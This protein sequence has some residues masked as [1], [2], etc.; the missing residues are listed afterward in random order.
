[1]KNNGKFV[2]RR[3]S[4]GRRRCWNLIRSERVWLW[5]SYTFANRTQCSMRTYSSSSRT[6]SVRL[7]RSN[8][9][10]CPFIQLSRPKLIYLQI[11]PLLFRAKPKCTR[12]D[13]SKTI[14]NWPLVC[15]SHTN[16]PT[17]RPTF[18]RALST[19]MFFTF[20]LSFIFKFR[21]KAEAQSKAT[22]S[23]D[24]IW[25]RN[26]QHTPAQLT[27]D[28]ATASD[29]HGRFLLLFRSSLF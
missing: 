29:F 6:W 17:A 2:R 11:F 25:F 23:R 28:D 16:F 27:S 20:F 5:R 3:D 14:T 1:M 9:R 13:D 7:R 18:P 10:L 8:P 24:L 15:V 4:E 19:K 26:R 22:R 12:Y 21:T